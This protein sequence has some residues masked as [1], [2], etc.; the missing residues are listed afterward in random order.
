M[1]RKLEFVLGT[2]AGLIGIGISLFL[3][4]D[5]FLYLFD[6]QDGGD[7]SLSYVCYRRTAFS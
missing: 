1:K 5:F 7:S 6:V 3:F 2:I 4:F